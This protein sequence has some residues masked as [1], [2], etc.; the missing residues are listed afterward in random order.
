MSETPSW[1]EHC[2]GVDPFEGDFGGGGSNDGVLRDVIQKARVESECHTCAQLN[3]R[4]TWV[5][6]RAEVYDGE[7]MRFRWCEPCCVAMMA[8]DG[9]EYERR[10]ELGRATRLATT[11]DGEQ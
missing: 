7:F 5:R 6:V 1:A 3:G 9:D 2:L 8:E 10:I 11:K 4:G